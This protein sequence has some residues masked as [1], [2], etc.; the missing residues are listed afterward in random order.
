[1]SY[2]FNNTFPSFGQQDYSQYYNPYE[3]GI[4]GFG[5]DA[6]DKTR[7]AE[8]ARTNAKDQYT[9]DVFDY[10]DIEAKDAVDQYNTQYM[11]GI[12]GFGGIT[13]E[14][15]AQIN[16]YQSTGAPATTAAAPVEPPVVAPPTAAD[17]TAAAQDQY[18]QGLGAYAEANDIFRDDS[19]PN[20]VYADAI[21]VSLEAYNR[22]LTDISGQPVGTVNTSSDYDWQD[23]DYVSTFTNPITGETVN[24]GAFAGPS[25]T[26][27]PA[28]G[29]S[30]A[31]GEQGKFIDYGETPGSGVGFG[32]DAVKGAGAV[33]TTAYNFY[34]DALGVNRDNAED[35][36]ARSEDILDLQNYYAEN[37]VTGSGTGNPVA[38]TV[39]TIS[40]YV[41]PIVRP[42]DAPPQPPQLRYF[43]PQNR[44]MNYQT[45]LYGGETLG[46]YRPY[47][48]PTANTSYTPPMEA[49]TFGSAPGMNTGGS[50]QGTTNLKKLFSNPMDNGIAQLPFNQQNDTLTQVFQAPFRPRR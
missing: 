46:N 13:P 17:R 50:V 6:K 38:E 28:T 7:A 45:Q 31:T 10:R 32:T 29:I 47:E 25:V 40:G 39:D 48:S 1:M 42:P 33:D 16:A 24:A 12:N 4:G 23:E 34:T 35:V 41:P 37:P 20:Q 22:Y 14:M 2:N 27:D 19:D 11:Q 9:S 5:Q 43:S 3:S 15:Q 49:S 8:E 18:N 44:L 21:G 36:A 26:Y 30:D